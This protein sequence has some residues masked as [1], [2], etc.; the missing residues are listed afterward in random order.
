M[1]S[2]VS[3][4]LIIISAMMVTACATQEYATV[5][6]AITLAGLTLSKEV[7]QKGDIA[8]P[9]GV[10][11]TFWTTNKEVAALISFK[12]LSGIINLRWDWFNPDGNLFHTKRAETIQTS[13]GKYFK[14]FNAWHVLTIAGDKV[15]K[16]PG[17]WTVAVYINGEHLASRSFMILEEDQ[18]LSLKRNR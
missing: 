14:E 1:P 11:S 8:V 16:M 18:S 3:V 7:L 5:K 6:P 13:E 12:N 2:W 15:A 10:G 17:N 9:Q 4:S